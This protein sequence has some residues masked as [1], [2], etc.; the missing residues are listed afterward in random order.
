MECLE[1]TGT[2]VGV[3]ETH[4]SIQLDHSQ[5]A[6]CGG[7]CGCSSACSGPPVV[8]VERGDLEQGDRVS[9]R[10]P[11]ANSYLAIALI[12]GLPLVLF[13]TGIG[14]GQALQGGDEVGAYSVAGGLAGLALAFLIAWLA[15]RAISRKVG[16]ASVERLTPESR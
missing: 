3:D 15:N 8:K 9:V 12:F 2:V 5:S 11:H 10:I 4:A 6:S 1:D 14:V 16:P 7:G 13:M